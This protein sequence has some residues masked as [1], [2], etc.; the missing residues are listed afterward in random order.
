MLHLLEEL[1]FDLGLF[2]NQLEAYIAKG[3]V[4]ESNV[5]MPLSNLLGQGGGLAAEVPWSEYFEDIHSNNVALNC[6]SSGKITNSRL[7]AGEGVVN[8]ATSPRGADIDSNTCT[9][10]PNPLAQQVGAAAVL[11]R[12]QLFEDTKAYVVAE[13]TSLGNLTNTRLEADEDF[14]N[15]AASS[16]SADTGNDMSAAVRSPLARVTA[17]AESPLAE[18]F[19]DSPADVCTA[20][21]DNND[22][23]QLPKRLHLFD[24]RNWND[25]KLASDAGCEALINLMKKNRVSQ[26]VKHAV[27]KFGVETLDDLVYCMRYYNDEEL[28][29]FIVLPRFQVLR[30]RKAA[31]IWETSGSAHEAAQPAQHQAALSPL[32]PQQEQ[33]AHNHRQQQQQQHGGREPQAQ[34]SRK[35]IGVSYDARRRK[36]VAQKRIDGKVV[37]LRRHSTAEAA[38]RAY[39]EACADHGLPRR[40]FPVG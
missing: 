27:L 4:V 32:P 3:G 22:L 1:R 19:E 23:S 11:P 36:W 34:S 8:E 16:G 39:D 24:G 31:E 26:S 5:N 35:F 29:K 14:V 10:S 15:V 2:R 7:E 12:A 25:C 37:Y 20:L 40:N 38:A 13:C 21:S 17:T 33:I 9:A 18:Q 30:L 6:T 28:M